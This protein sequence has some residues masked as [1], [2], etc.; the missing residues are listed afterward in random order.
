MRLNKPV[1]IVLA[2]LVMFA[3]FSS[4][5]GKTR[6]AETPL[7]DV[8]EYVT[9]TAGMLEETDRIQISKMLAQ[10]AQDTGNQI[11]AVTIPSL[12]GEPIEDYTIRL[13]EKVKPGEDKKDNGAI[14]L[15]A[16]DEHKIRIETG[17]GLEEFLPDG[18]CGTI[19]R[20]VISPAFR[21]G[22]FAGGIRQGLAA[23]IHY[24][25]PDYKIG[26]DSEYVAPVEERHERGAGEW[27]LPL[28]IAIF[29]MGFGGF[30]G[31]RRRRWYRGGFG[32]SGPTF[33]GGGWGSGSGGSGFSDGGGFSGGGGDFGGGGASGD[34]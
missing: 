30:H 27:I 21:N 25:S 9:D 5:T 33:W 29:I 23:M 6:A 8:K 19:I 34:W 4:V 16:R 32:S 20:E 11:I 28:I 17:Y 10:Y 31:G 13:A 15:I 1:R 2:L 3:L 18:R 14:L 22:D 7:P 12:G 24:V 26:A